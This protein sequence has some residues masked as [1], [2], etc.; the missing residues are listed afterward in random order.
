MAKP[1]G[2]KKIQVSVG[3]EEALRKQLE[4]AAKES[5]RSLSGEIVKRLRDSFEQP[6]E[7]ATA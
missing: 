4:A 6:S 1:K 3:V 7:A 2:E 5:V